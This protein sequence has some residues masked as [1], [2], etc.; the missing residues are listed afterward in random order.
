MKCTLVPLIALLMLGTPTAFAAP[1]HAN[2]DK[3][4]LVAGAKAPGASDS[5]P[6]PDNADKRDKPGKPGKPDKPDKEPK[7]GGPA[8]PP[9]RPVVLDQEKALDAVA[10]GEAL[11]LTRIITLAEAANGGRVIDAKLMH[12][13]GILVY[14]L[15]LLSNGGVARRLFYYARSGNPIRFT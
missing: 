8:G 11:P 5:F 12:I 14:R 9:A 15:T 13:Q 4:T 6:K 1:D 2:D 10:R 7:K 3:G